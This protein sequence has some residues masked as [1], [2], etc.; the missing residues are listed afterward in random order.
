MKI[1]LITLYLP[2]QRSHHAG[3]RYVYELIRGLCGTHEIH[4][5]TRAGADDSDDLADL[6]MLCQSVQVHLHAPTAP[7]TFVGFL[8]RTWSKLCFSM[9]A[10][11]EIRSGL[12]DVVQVEWVESAVF[13]RRSGTAMLLDA[14]DVLSK[15]REREA[16]AA[17]GTRRLVLYCIYFATRSL[18]L[19]I[20]KQFDAVITLSA[21][22]QRYLLRRLNNKVPVR[23]ISPPAGLDIT[24]QCYPKDKNT[25]LF[26][27]SYRSTYVSAA[28]Y[29]YRRV[30]PKVRLLVPNARLILAGSNPPATLTSLGSQDQA[31]TIPGFVDNLD[32]LYK[33][34]AVF[35]APVLVGGG[36]IVKIL[37]AMAAGT[38]VVTTSYGNEG[39]NAVPGKDVLIADDPDLFAHHIVKLMLDDAYAAEL[40]MSGQRFVRAHFRIESAINAFESTYSELSRT[41]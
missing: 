34:A 39:I 4:L 9:R 32:E 26:L 36:I 19:H 13:I 33:K 18:E 6:R 16:M 20:A 22:D 31:V 8:K 17:R 23:V 2:K 11:R 14:H 27:A 29:L 25:I 35:A 28:L 5:F 3:G 40:G 12:Y 1:L 38:P 21:Y 10:N 41:L 7:N 24:D 15:P 30:F 37:D